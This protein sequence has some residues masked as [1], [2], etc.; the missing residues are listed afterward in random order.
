MAIP[1]AE[2]AGCSKQPQALRANFPN[3]VLYFA[4]T[5]QT[6]Q[7]MAQNLGTKKG[8]FSGWRVRLDGVFST[9]VK[10]LKT[11]TSEVKRVLRDR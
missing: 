6:W 2:I 3:G 5:R 7:G 8:Q 11:E 1:P 9:V 10:R 4:H